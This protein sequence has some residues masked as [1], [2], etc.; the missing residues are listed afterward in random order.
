MLNP[1]EATSNPKTNF[2]QQASSPP[3]IS[4]ENGGSVEPSDF[5]QTQTLGTI[6]WMAPEFLEHKVFT[7][8]SEIYSF[9]IFLYEV[10]CMPFASG[11]DSSPYGDLQGVQV[12]FQVVDHDLRPKVT[13]TMEQG[14]DKRVLQLMKTCWTRSQADRPSLA[15]IIS[16]LQ[17]VRE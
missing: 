8:K 9:G 3:S 15:E 17:G 13:P 5:S 11:R 6:P 7:A 14:V 1:P 16:C 12:M 4:F 10:F 2:G